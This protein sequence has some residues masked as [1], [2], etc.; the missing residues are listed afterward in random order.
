MDDHDYAVLALVKGGSDPESAQATLRAFPETVGAMAPKGREI[1]E[2]EES[3]IR[4]EEFAASPTGREQAAREVLARREAHAEKVS[5]GRVLLEDGGNADVAGMSEAEVLH[6][7]RIGDFDSTVATLEE[8]DRE[9]ERI[10]QDGSYAQKSLV[11]RMRV[12]RDLGGSVQGF[13]SYAIQSGKSITDSPQ[14][15]SYTQ[16]LI[17]GDAAERTEDV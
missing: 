14:I 1:F 3:R 12:A 9:A 2:A 15:D 4:A 6:Y 13:D 10:I 16:A 5:L 17:D 7:S 8:K 11:E